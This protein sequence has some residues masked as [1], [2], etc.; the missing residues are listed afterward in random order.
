MSCFGKKKKKR[1][2][3]TCILEQVLRKI[4]IT[5]DIEENSCLC[6]LAQKEDVKIAFE[7]PKLS[8]NVMK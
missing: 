3:K 1:S 2:S 7:N 6:K 5:P 8:K 4:A